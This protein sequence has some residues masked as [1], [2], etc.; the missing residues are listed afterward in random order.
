MSKRHLR[1][2][3][4]H[5]RHDENADRNNSPDRNLENCPSASPPLEQ[6]ELYT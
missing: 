6:H 1:S 3:H 5:E 2:A 4:K